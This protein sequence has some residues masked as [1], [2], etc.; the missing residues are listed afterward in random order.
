MG[1]DLLMEQLQLCS[2]LVGRG[3]FGGLRKSPGLLH[4]KPEPQRQKA[5][6]QGQHRAQPAANPTVTPVLMVLREKDVEPDPSLTPAL[7]LTLG[8]A[9][10]LTESQLAHQ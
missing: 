10:P 6:E 8:K 1:P 9:H 4:R 3:M 2:H 7:S 5:L